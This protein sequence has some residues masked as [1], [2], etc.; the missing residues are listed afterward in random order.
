M[1]YNITI[2]SNGS[3]YSL[4][5]ANKEVTQREMDLYFASFFGASEEFISKIKKVEIIDDNQIKSINEIEQVDKKE[6][7][8]LHVDKNE[9][10]VEQPI[11]QQ[12]QVQQ[13]K[14]E[15]PRVEQIQ[16]QQ[17][18]V[19]PQMVQP[20]VEQQKVVQ[21]EVYSE[22]TLAQP[23]QQ[24]AYSQVIAEQPVLQQTYSQPVSTQ[25]VQQQALQPQ[26]VQS[27]VVQPQVLQQEALQQQPQVQ[28]Q[29]SMPVQIEKQVQTRVE[30]QPQVEMQLKQD[31]ADVQQ[32]IPSQNYFEENIPSVAYGRVEENFEHQKEILEIE[33]EDVSSIQKAINES[34]QN[35]YNSL[36]NVE[37][38]ELDESNY[39]IFNATEM[40]VNHVSDIQNNQIQHETPIQSVVFTNEKVS[41]L[42]N[43]NDFDSK[44][45]TEIETINSQVEV[46][47]AFTKVEVDEYDEKSNLPIKEDKFDDEDYFKFE[48]EVV[49]SEV[50]HQKQNDIDELISMAQNKLDSFDMNSSSDINKLDELVINSNPVVDNNEQYSNFNADNLEEVSDS[51]VNQQQEEALNNEA[52]FKSMQN[53]AQ[54]ETQLQ[55]APPYVVQPQV[56][57]I[58]NDINQ[59]QMVQPQIVQ[60]PTQAEAP[61][62]QSEIL[63]P[64]QQAQTPVVQPAR[65]EVVQNEFVQ[66]QITQVQPVQEP[67]QISDYQTLQAQEQLNQQQAQAK[68]EFAYQQDFKLFLS[69]FKPTQTSDTFL[70][71]AFYIKNILKQE[72]FTMKFINSKLFQA[73]GTIADMTIVDEL[74]SKEYI[75]VINSPDFKKYCITKDG[76]GYFI[77]R[78][79]G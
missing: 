19:Q 15:Q 32:N 48:Q 4:V 37:L 77:N 72:N 57:Q 63:Q 38:E 78:L 33:F 59:M 39:Q 20:Q 23:I 41:N 69:D 8:D 24:Q 68:T 52:K 70:I 13:P 40:Q 64:Q 50:P 51:Y 61:T 74:T 47:N 79:Q 42:D 12:P 16:V 7:L 71:C 21:Q 14:V 22:P 54:I 53:L 34:S 55:T 27:Q 5:S 58:Q 9:F 25:M 1:Y 6:S 28:Q 17:Q 46:Q 65:V 76:E 67:S 49:I 30:I 2:K 3:E 43:Q 11:N 29:N 36:A 60:P 26:V 73:T 31:F 62:I 45:N 44:N 35:K 10:K 75:R 66:P 56:Q 18:T